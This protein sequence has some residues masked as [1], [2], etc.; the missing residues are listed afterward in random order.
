VKDEVG[1]SCI[2]RRAGKR[3][4][5]LLDATVETIRDAGFEKGDRRD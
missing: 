5:R 4:A 2:M 3:S 1:E